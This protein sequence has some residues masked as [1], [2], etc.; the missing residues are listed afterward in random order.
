MIDA[1]V[2]GPTPGNVS[3]CSADAVF[4]STGADPPDGDFPTGD[5]PSGVDAGPLPTLVDPVGSTGSG[6]SSSPTLGTYRR[7]PSA[8][9]AARL[10]RLA[11]ASARS[12][13]AA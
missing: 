12:P 8:S 1:A 13:P 9:S 7:C 5:E 4:R 11:S 10:R 6:G 3:S 2:D